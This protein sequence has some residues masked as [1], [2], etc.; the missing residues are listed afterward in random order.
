MYGLSLNVLGY[1]SELIR[2]Q[3]DVVISVVQ[4]AN[5]QL[6]IITV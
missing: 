6:Q 5:Y 3:K 1:G 4:W 2:A